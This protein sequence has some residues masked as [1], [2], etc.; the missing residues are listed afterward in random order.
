ML[1]DIN[2]VV[3]CHDV[4][5]DLRHGGVDQHGCARAR[6]VARFIRHRRRYR[7][8]AVGDTCHVGCRNVQR[9]DT[10][11]LNLRGVL[12]AIEGYSDRLTGFGA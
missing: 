2:D 9:P 1:G 4:K 10:V 12:V 6:R 7:R 5:A 11:R 8:I 3:A